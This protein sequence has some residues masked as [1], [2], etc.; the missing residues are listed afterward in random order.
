M[1]Y[2]LINRLRSWYQDLLIVLHG[3]TSH[4]P[5]PSIRAQET[6]NHPSYTVTTPHSICD[7]QSVGLA[8]TWNEP[9]SC[10]HLERWISG[11]AAGG[12]YFIGYSPRGTLVPS[13][14]PLL[15]TCPAGVFTRNDA[16]VEGWER[17]WLGKIVFW[18][19]TIRFG[20]MGT[21]RAEK[22]HLQPSWSSG[23]S[24]L[25]FRWGAAMLG[26]KNQGPV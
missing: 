22:V 4:S 15:L 26:D 2:I 16:G 19:T 14:L 25:C 9:W 5:H 11:L 6:W 17:G 10:S 20:S 21:D 24:D 1:S 18:S 13:A 7:Y 23:K 3:G 8:P 12:S